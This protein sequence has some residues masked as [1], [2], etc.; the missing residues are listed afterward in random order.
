MFAKLLGRGAPNRQVE[1]VVA[2]ADERSAVWDGLFAD[3]AL[4]TVLRHCS[5]D[6]VLDVGSGAGKHADIFEEHGK[7][8][9]AVDFGLSVYYQQK[10]SRR[11][12]ILA[13][14]YE[15][16]FPE[17]FDLIWAS[18]VLEHQPNPQ[19]FL[20]KVH[21]DLKE[22]GWF[23]VTV[24]PLKH[25]IVGGHVTLWN[26][27]LLLYQLIL[28]RFNCRNA[29]IKKYGYNISVIV[30][31]ATIPSLPPLHHDSG[32][33]DRLA[34]FFPPACSERFNGDIDEMNWPAT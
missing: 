18:H 27:G 20:Q 4:D 30:R 33:I 29:W 1:Q 22:G 6:S 8:V 34:E 25:E 5:F 13:N 15:Y 31:K 11:R 17:P 9:T 7:S 26:A 32:D 23:A 24:P 28:A 19:S 21:A 2:P 14:Y 16:K 10:R 12:E 3:E